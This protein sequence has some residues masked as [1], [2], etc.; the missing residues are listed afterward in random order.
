MKNRESKSMRIT[1]STTSNNQD[2]R[3]LLEPEYKANFK[4]TVK[5][6]PPK[7][8]VERIKVSFFNKEILQHDKMV[9]KQCFHYLFR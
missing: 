1:Y 8:Q 5:T 2:K 7:T 9:T 6:G 3:K 4:K